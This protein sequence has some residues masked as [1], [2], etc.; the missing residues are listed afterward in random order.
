MEVRFFNV[1]ETNQLKQ[2]IHEVWA[3]NHIFVREEKL[4]NYM[5]LEN[6]AKDLLV[7]DQHYSFLGAWKDHSLIGLLGVMPFTLNVCGKKEVG[8]TLANWGVLPEQR[9][10]GA[11]LAL[12]Q[13]VQKLNP[14]IILAL[15]INE[16]VAKL[17]K[18]M[19]WK[20]DEQT[21]RW[22]GLVQK[23]KTIDLMLNGNPYPLR[24]WNEI[25][26]IKTNSNY[27]VE[28]VDSLDEEMWNTFYWDG[29]AKDSIG[30]ARDF[31]FLQWRYFEHP[32][33]HY[34]VF[35]CK[36]GTGK[37][38]GLAIVRVEN[39]LNGEKIG[40][41]VEFISSDQDSAISLAN[42][43]IEMDRDILF[44]DFFCFSSISS[45]GLE[46]V[47]FKQVLKSETDQIVLPL[48]FQP[49]DLAV[50]DLRAS[51]FV[52]PKFAKEYNLVKND[53][54]YI[55]KGDADQDRPN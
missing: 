5:F 29:F 16:T 53:L 30:F 18:L 44:F 20:V 4:L 40:R 8:C 43:M 38:K 10:S 3:K 47:G 28:K 14:S 41:I 31:S 23:E 6:P 15:G 26:Q 51:M 35:T 37:Y 27:T 21:P 39:I 19:K 49:L 11:G 32:F 50:T 1:S 7:N 42:A 2:G 17:Y 48:R 33:F 13:H 24:Y 34:H 54:W 55:T 12:M 9:N 36:D 45:W 46:A 22:I 52:T 25:K